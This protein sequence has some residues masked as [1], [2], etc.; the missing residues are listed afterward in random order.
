MP[1]SINVR[2]NRYLSEWRLLKH[3]RRFHLGHS[4]YHSLVLENNR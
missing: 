1:L 3:V 2:E 4:K